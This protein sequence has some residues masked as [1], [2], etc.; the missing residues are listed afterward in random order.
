M[1]LTATELEIIRSNT[2]D[3][4]E[5]LAQAA[6]ANVHG[7]L[8]LPGDTEL[9]RDVDIADFNS[10]ASNFDPDGATAPHSWLR[11][12]F[13]GDDDID[14]TDFNVRA[15]NFMP[16]G[17]G[18]AAIPE[19]SSVVFLLLGLRCATFRHY[20]HR[21]RATRCR[22]ANSLSLWP[23]GRTDPQT[24]QRARAAESTSATHGLATRVPTGA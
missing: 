19:P 24:G 2:A 4:T 9:D 23:M 16:G 21:T 1:W 12:N 13:E 18:A 15:S 10:L 17:Y 6:T 8:Y 22:G 7:S 14:I 20:L 5:W 11:G 3:I